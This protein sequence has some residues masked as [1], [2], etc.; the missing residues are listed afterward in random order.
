M[1]KKYKQY[2]IESTSSLDTLGQYVSKLAEKDEFIRE[3]VAQYTDGVNQSVDI[4][5]AINVL[6]DDDKIDLLKRVESHLSGEEKEADVS[7]SKIERIQE[8]IG[9]G[10]GV[11]NSF[12]KCLTALGLKDNKP[13]IDDTPSKYL[14]YFKFADMPSE[15]VQ[16][17]FKRFRSMSSIPVDNKPTSL[18]FGLR[19]Y[20]KIEYGYNDEVIGSFKIGRKVFNEIKNSKLKSLSGLR[21]SLSDISI[22]DIKLLSDIKNSMAEFSPGFSQK[23]MSPQL[24]GRVYSFGYYGYGNWNNGQMADDDITILKEKLKA[25]L[26]RN[27]WAGMVQLS[28]VPDKFWVYVNIKLK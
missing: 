8:S 4:S 24:S 25:H 15:K 2:I 7:V 9:Y 17:V 21:N 28:I 5:N 10:K 13:E 3:L 12:L 23:Q 11:F 18:F 22:E 16:Y 27:K 20:G 1:I 19:V 6:D 14:L 26:G